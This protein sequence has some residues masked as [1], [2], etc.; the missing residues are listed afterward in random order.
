MHQRRPVAIFFPD[1]IVNTLS[2]SLSGAGQTRDTN[3]PKLNLEQKK[4]RRELLSPWPRYCRNVAMPHVFVLRRSN[5][6][7]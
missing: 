4:M 5:S 6:H 2:G 1:A 3:G 7:D